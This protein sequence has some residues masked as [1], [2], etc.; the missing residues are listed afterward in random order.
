M[1]GNLG[2]LASLMG[3]VKEIQSNVKQLKAEL[4]TLEFTATPASGNV[5]ATVNGEFRLVKLEFAPGA[6]PGAAEVAEAVNSAVESAKLTIAEKM[7]AAT[8]GI[9]LPGLL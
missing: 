3:R 7:K 1:F 5:T 8:G 2:E 6:T 4:P 9:D